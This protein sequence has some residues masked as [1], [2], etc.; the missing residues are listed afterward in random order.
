MTGTWWRPA[1]RTRS[2][3][4][5]NSQLVD[6][7]SGVIYVTTAIVPLDAPTKLVDVLATEA[8]AVGNLAIGDELN[9]A[10]PLPN[11]SS[12]AVVTVEVTAGLNAEETDAYRTR[13]IKRFQGPPQGGAYADYRIWGIEVLGIIDIFPYTSATTQSY[14]EQCD[15][16]QFDPPR[17]PGR[18]DVFAE[19]D[20]S[21]NDD[22]IPTVA[23]L[24][25]VFDAIQLDVGGKAS[26]R[27][28]TAL[29]RVFAIT[30]NP[31]TVEVVGL[32]FEPEDPDALTLLKPQ[33]DAA[34]DEHLRSRSPFIVGL[35]ILPRVDLVDVP[36]VSGVVSQVATAAGA[37]FNLVRIFD[38]AAAPVDVQELGDGEKAKLLNAECDYVDS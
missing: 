17:L 11:I 25:A 14:Q 37:R 28:A 27:P 4:R 32:R 12:I 22:G 16:P 18:V 7:D 21:G 15:P 34:V 30:R 31:F 3:S 38:V 1:P 36:A 6:P 2:G 33:I 29:V 24:E 5:A 8:G 26:R 35:S 20:T 10:N 23:Q 19:A 13:I 9:F